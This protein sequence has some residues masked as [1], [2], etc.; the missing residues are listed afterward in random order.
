M[1]R[2]VSARGSVMGGA[3]NNPKALPRQPGDRQRKK[4]DPA[5]ARPTESGQKGERDHWQ[6]ILRRDKKMGQPIV[7]RPKAC[8]HQMSTARK[9]RRS[10]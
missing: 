6:Q 7:K 2:M 10:A 3:S 9:G 5:E 8:V 4:D 1:V